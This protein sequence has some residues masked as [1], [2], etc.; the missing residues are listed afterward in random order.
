MITIYCRDCSTPREIKPQDAFQV[1]RCVPCQKKYTN[2]QR[3]VRAQ[4]KRGRRVGQIADLD[5]CVARV[6]AGRMT[7]EDYCFIKWGTY[8]LSYDQVIRMN[9]SDIEEYASFDEEDKDYYRRL[10]YSE[11]DLVKIHQERGAENFI[12]NEYECSARETYEHMKI[13][14]DF[15]YDRVNK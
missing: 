7:W 15:A 14:I 9:G 10:G 8:D 11:E 1:K 2:D 5:A 6:K 13:W 12:Q 3:R 4:I